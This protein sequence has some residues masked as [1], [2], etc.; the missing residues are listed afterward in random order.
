MHLRD[1]IPLILVLPAAEESG[2]G[3]AEG[4]AAHGGGGETFDG[5][6]AAVYPDYVA[7]GYR[8]GDSG[9]RNGDLQTTQTDSR[10]CGGVEEDGMKCGEG[11]DRAEEGSSSGGGN[12]V[13]QVWTLLVT[14]DVG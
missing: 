11:R 5:H 13:G 12:R 9:S 7:R 2:P 3:G 14:V 4:E 10:E 6:V 1:T 8:R